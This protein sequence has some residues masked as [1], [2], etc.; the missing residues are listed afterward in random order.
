MMTHD[1]AAP[2]G[3]SLESAA[4]QVKAKVMVVASAQDQMVIPHRPWSLLG[5]FRLRW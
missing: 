4:K 3:D 1:I 5:F 2:F